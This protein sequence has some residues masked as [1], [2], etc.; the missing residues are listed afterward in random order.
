[1]EVFEEIKSFLGEDEKKDSNLIAPF[2]LL[3]K[4]AVESLRYRA[5]V[6]VNSFIFLTDNFFFFL[7]L[8]ILWSMTVLQLP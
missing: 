7:N 2:S 1:M 4:N 8:A 6:I 5:E 3:S